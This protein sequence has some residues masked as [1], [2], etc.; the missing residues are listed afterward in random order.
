MAA[1]PLLQPQE[2]LPP[3]GDAAGIAQ[4]EIRPLGCDKFGQLQ[5]QN[6]LSSA[7]PARTS[8]SK[9]RKALGTA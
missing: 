2:H 5:S 3:E 8:P 7:L 1:Q 4:V 6:F 9:A